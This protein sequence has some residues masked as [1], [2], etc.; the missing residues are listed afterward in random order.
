MELNELK[1]YADSVNHVMLRM[2]LTQ[3]VVMGVDNAKKITDE[4]IENCQENAMMTKEFVQDI[5]RTTRELAKYEIWDIF[6]YIKE[7]VGIKGCAD[8]KEKA[9]RYLVIAYNAICL[10]QLDEIYDKEQLMYELGC[11]EDEYDE[12]MC[13]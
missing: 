4:D 10:G 12:I 8:Y 5:F 1:K 9:N 2:A 7:E 3:L 6:A 13:E 11:N